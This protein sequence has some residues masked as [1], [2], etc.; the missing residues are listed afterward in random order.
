MSMLFKEERR[1]VKALDVNEEITQDY[2]QVCETF[3]QMIEL[4]QSENLKM[5]TQN[6]DFQER[7]FE[8]IKSEINTH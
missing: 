6:S 8:N 1:D 4:K 5:L 2:W 7:V 3:L